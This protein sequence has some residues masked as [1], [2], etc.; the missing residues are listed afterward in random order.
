MRLE[1][2]QNWPNND[3]N[4]PKNVENQAIWPENIQNVCVQNTYRGPKPRNFPKNPTAGPQTYWATPAQL[5]PQFAE[6]P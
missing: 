5:P 3:Q 2:L 6:T 1:N 4:R